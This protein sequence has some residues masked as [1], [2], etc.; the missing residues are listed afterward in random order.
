MILNLILSTL[1]SFSLTFT[2]NDNISGIITDKNTN[3]PLTGVKIETNIEIVY[4]D[5]DG[6]FEISNIGDTLKLNI[7]YISYE[8]VNLLLTEKN[9]EILLVNLKK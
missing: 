4:T 9:N 3:E 1:L 7:S 8:D 2:S 6:K 5:F